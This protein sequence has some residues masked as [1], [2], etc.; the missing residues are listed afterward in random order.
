MA[1]HGIPL[2]GGA[3][4]LHLRTGDIVDEK[5]GSGGGLEREEELVTFAGPGCAFF[6]FFGVKVAAIAACRAVL[7]DC[8]RFIN[9]GAVIFCAAE[10]WPG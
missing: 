6:Q 7:W 8:A 5:L 9:C 3:Q 4:G 10:A 2:S 1:G